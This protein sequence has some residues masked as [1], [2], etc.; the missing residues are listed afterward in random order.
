M[1][2]ACQTFT[3]HPVTKTTQ[4]IGC[5]MVGGCGGVVGFGGVLVPWIVHE[6]IISQRVTLTK[7]SR[8]KALHFAA[9][10]SR[11][12]EVD[13]CTR[14]SAVLLRR[15]YGEVA[16]RRISAMLVRNGLL[17]VGR[18]YRANAGERSR[19]K[20]YSFP[21]AVRAARKVTVVLKWRPN[22]QR[23]KKE[24]ERLSAPQ[25][26]VAAAAARLTLAP[27]WE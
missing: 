17:I 8:E 27:G 13:P 26:Y 9:M 22:R 3:S 12:T 11:K 5:G 6:R 1:T 7:I 23:A 18:S 2:S 14:L 19:C 20:S 24:A 10:L 21:D 15:R 25:A 4:H 16:W